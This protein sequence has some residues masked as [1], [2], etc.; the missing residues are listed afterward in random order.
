MPYQMEENRQSE[1]LVKIVGIVGGICLVC[2]LVLAIVAEEQ[3]PVIGWI[4]VPM[5]VM[6]IVLGAVV[7]NAK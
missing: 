2:V 1:A 5:V 4:I 3:L 6:S 7:W